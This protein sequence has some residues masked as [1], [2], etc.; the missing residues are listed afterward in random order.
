[1]QIQ[2]EIFEEFFNNLRGS[3]LPTSLVHKLI[4]LREKGQ[5]GN[6]ERLIELIKEYTKDDSKDK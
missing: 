2:D 5:I 1:M 3:D 4:V 6:K